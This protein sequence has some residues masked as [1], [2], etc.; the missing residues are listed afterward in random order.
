MNI[1]QQQNKPART[2]RRIAAL[3]VGS[4]GLLTA[5]T[6]HGAVIS[7]VL[8][9]RIDPAD[10]DFSIPAGN[11]SG[12]NTSSRQDALSIDLD[13]NGQADVRVLGRTYF[14]KDKDQ[15]FNYASSSL[16]LTSI[17]A[18][19]AIE[20]VQDST[21]GKANFAREHAED[22][23]IGAAIG[24]SDTFYSLPSQ[25][26]ADF[27]GAHF[28][29]DEKVL[30]LFQEFFRDIK[31]RDSQAAA[32]SEVLGEVDGPQSGST[33]DGP[34]FIGFR[35]DAGNNSY[36]YGFIQ[37]DDIDRDVPNAFTRK[38]AVKSAATVV[39]FALESTPDLAITTF[40]VENPPIIPEPGTLALLGLGGVLVAGRPRRRAEA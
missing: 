15:D 6:A 29:D 12:P 39:G 22:L 21:D 4:T 5:T 14:E 24:P 28:D 19:T 32:F 36:N 40:D 35:L 8:N 2:S 34:L 7:Q 11:S 33:L 23:S 17:Q 18:G 37:F 1:T 9:E 31:S 27:G 13:A 26:A 20:L 3:A 25:R 30:L 38:D 10:P 16:H